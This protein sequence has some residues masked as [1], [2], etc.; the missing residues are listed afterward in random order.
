MIKKK[1]YEEKSKTQ[2]VWYDSSMMVY[3]E[4]VESDVDNVGEL[5]MI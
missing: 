3:S 5:Y 1:I 4:M 2:K